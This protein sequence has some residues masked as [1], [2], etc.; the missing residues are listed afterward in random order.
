MAGFSKIFRSGDLA[1]MEKGRMGTWNS[2]AAWTFP[3]AWLRGFRIE[4]GE[5]E[6]VLSSQA[7]VEEAA[8]ALRE[9]PQGKHLVAYVAARNSGVTEEALRSG[10]AA[11]LPDFMLP[12]F[13]V[14]VGRLP[15]NIN[16]KVDRQALAGLQGGPV[17]MPG[18]SMGDD[19]E[20]KLQGNFLP[21]LFGD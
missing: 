20:A 13:F 7:G 6:A 16:G 12:S 10:A 15:L 19:S 21:K 1:P 14:I 5:I 17:A 8:V 11:K 2:W 18:I 4:L 9:G 3:S